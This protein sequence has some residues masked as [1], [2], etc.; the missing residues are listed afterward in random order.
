MALPVLYLSTWA[1]WWARGKEN[2]FSP[3]LTQSFCTSVYRVQ[4]ARQSDPYSHSPDRSRVHTVLQKHPPKRNPLHSRSRTLLCSIH[5]HRN[6]LL[7]IL[8]LYSR[9]CRRK[10]FPGS[11]GRPSPAF[12][13][14]TSSSSSCGRWWTRSRAKWA[15][16]AAQI[17]L[18]IT[19]SITVFRDINLFA[20]K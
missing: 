3:S 12:S 20:L 15:A 7:I 9:S 11:C 10:W 17:F 14:L 19:C 13:P 2:V 5:S 18:D 6:Q 1:E 16:S 8:S 4:T